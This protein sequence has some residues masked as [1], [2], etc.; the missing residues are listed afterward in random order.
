[1][2]SAIIA[3]GLYGNIGLKVG[4]QYAF[5]R[6]ALIWFK[7]IYANI[8]QDIFGGPELVSK[9]GRYIW[10]GLVIG[11]WALAFVI[12]SAIPQF[13]NISGTF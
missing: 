10:I 2:I 9:G 11:Y 4:T 8:V 7:V 13:S 5:E 3:A 12:A 1:L 6:H